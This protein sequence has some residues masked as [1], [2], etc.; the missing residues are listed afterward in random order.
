MTD[1][2]IPLQTRIVN[3][4]DLK[5]GELAQVQGSARTPYIVK[6][7]GGGGH[8]GAGVGQVEL[9]PR[10]ELGHGLVRPTGMGQVVGGLA[11]RGSRRQHEFQDQ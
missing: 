1:I 9:G 11:V 7:V 4:P 3:M 10:P 5:D 6:N 8:V 2:S